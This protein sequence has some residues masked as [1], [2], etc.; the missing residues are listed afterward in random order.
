[1]GGREVSN[2]TNV[3]LSFGFSSTRIGVSAHCT[4]LKQSADQYKC[5]LWL[6]FG[7]ARGQDGSSFAGTACVRCLDQRFTL[8][9]F[10]LCRSGS[11]PEKNFCLTAR[12]RNLS[13]SR[14]FQLSKASPAGH[15]WLGVQS[16]APLSSRPVWFFLGKLHCNLCQVLFFLPQKRLIN[17]TD[18][19]HSHPA[20]VDHISSYCVS[21]S[22]P[23]HGYHPG[24]CFLF[25]QFQFLLLE[26]N[27]G[28]LRT[29]YGFPTSHAP[30][31]YGLRNWGLKGE[32]GVGGSRARKRKSVER[33]AASLAQTLVY[34]VWKDKSKP[35]SAI[36]V[37][38]TGQHGSTSES[39]VWPRTW[40]W[41]MTVE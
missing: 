25:V 31:K 14:N 32:F 24:H 39:R 1:V 38:P 10:R 15:S 34:R 19:G 3:K 7:K 13:R 4:F 27:L 2:N 6:I 35:R 33:R 36:S 11:Q 23:R 41:T 29:G 17:T 28:V 30:T 9:V 26:A 21:H 5:I 20:S 18:M 16:P 12:R 37:L 40:R 22:S 8:C